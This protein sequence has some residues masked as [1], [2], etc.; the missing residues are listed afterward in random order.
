MKKDN[1]ISLAKFLWRKFPLELHGFTGDLAFWFLLGTV[2][3]SI[4]IAVSFYQMSMVGLGIVWAV[5]SILSGLA[6]VKMSGDHDMDV[7]FP[8]LYATYL[9]V[10]E[11]LS[12]VFVIHFL[13]WLACVPMN[14]ARHSRGD[15][16]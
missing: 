7:Y 16:Y 2:V 14:I 5:V 4:A 12:G 10:S 8:C 15:L 11:L 1:S 9:I 3:G 13:W 6:A